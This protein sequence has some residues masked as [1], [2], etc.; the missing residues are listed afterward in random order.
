[1]N[2]KTKNPSQSG[3]PLVSIITVVY[4]GAKTLEQTIQSVISQTYKNIEY[5]VIDG[6]SSDGTL[7]IIKKYEDR[8]TYWVSGPDSGIYDAMNKGIRK[9]HGEIIGI[10]NSDDYYEKETAAAVVNEFKA[11]PDT[12]IYGLL[13]YI[14]DGR[15]LMV[16]AHHHDYLRQ[17]MI[18]H[19]ASFVPKALY[20]RYGLFNLKYSYCADY[21]FMLRLFESHVPFIRI[22]RVLANFRTDGVSSSLK[23]VLEN[24]RILKEHGVISS[25]KSLFLTVRAFIS[26]YIKKFF[27][28]A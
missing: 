3:R 8:I 19:P 21:D 9:S 5:I 12:V 10:I 14:K 23:S 11:H 13:R 15:E 2:S 4:N 7:D 6:G 26:H 28:L 17:F 27:R 16:M 1:M 20:D 24:Y 18:P 25:R 22:D